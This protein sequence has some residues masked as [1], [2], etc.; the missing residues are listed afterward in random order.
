MAGA[1]DVENIMLPTGTLQELD[2]S[3]ADFTDSYTP[4]LTLTG[5]QANMK[6]QLVNRT[7]EKFTKNHRVSS[8][9]V[10]KYNTTQMTH[11]VFMELKDFNTV[12]LSGFEVEEKV[13]D[14]LYLVHF[15]L[16]QDCLFNKMLMNCDNLQR[17]VFGKHLVNVKN[18]S[19]SSCTA[20]DSLVF[21]AKDIN[22]SNNAFR[23][24]RRLRSIGTY[25]PSKLK[26][27]MFNELFYHS[28]GIEELK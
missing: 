24:V 17:I 27:N 28:V 6:G 19:F 15:M 1:V 3:Q 25:Q 13:R 7:S 20:L 5:R 10:Q 2:M 26:A 22:F 4:Y 9:D 16:R 23:G 18:Y 21:Y 11:K 8:V 12:K 14:S